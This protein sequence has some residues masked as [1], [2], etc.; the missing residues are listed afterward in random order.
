TGWVRGVSFTPDGSRVLSASLDKTVRIWDTST[1][2]SRVLSGHTENVYSVAAFPDGK[3]ALSG[4]RDR[5][6]RLWSL[7]SGECLK[8]IEGHAD[9][10]R[11]VAIGK[12]PR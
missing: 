7:E 4:S 2:L 12:D 6:L 3:R 8:V 9:V 1:G 10:V 5:T 11:S